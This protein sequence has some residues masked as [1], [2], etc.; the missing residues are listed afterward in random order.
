M[1]SAEG[2]QSFALQQEMSYQ[3]WAR[4]AGEPQ[5][6]ITANA[7]ANPDN[8]AM[9]PPSAMLKPTIRPG[10]CSMLRAHVTTG[11][12]ADRMEDCSTCA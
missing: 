3:S 11:L 10:K 1:A 6:P 5:A 9:L 8:R 4:A 2:R 12:A 7:T